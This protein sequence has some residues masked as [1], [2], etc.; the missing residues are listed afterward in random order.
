[1]FENLT[2]YPSL[3]SARNRQI[4][5]D[6]LTLALVGIFIWCG[7]KVHDV[8]ASLSVLGTAVQ[9]AGSNV[10]NSF[11]S[12]ANAV[13]GIPVVGGSLSDAF[14]NAGQGTGGNVAQTAQAGVDAINRLALVLG[15]VTAGLPIAVL[16]AVGLPRRVRGIQ[17]MTAATRMTQVDLTDP[18][19]RRLLA[20]RAAFGLPFRELLPYTSDP[21]GDLARGEY[22][23]LI[24]AALADAGLMPVTP[25]R[26][27]SER[28]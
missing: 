20:M 16:A 15:I 4:L 5:R 8:V 3:P 18:E 1:M 7:V 13:A 27:L 28:P 23:A 17:N 10:Q 2:L 14:H 19:R 11:D 22:D 6:L 9:E 21:F 26:T 24:S 12:V 25:N